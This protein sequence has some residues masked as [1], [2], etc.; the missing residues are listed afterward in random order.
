MTAQEHTTPRLVALAA[1][2]VLLLNYPI[3]YLF[4]RHGLVGGIPVLYLYLLVTWGLLILITALVLDARPF[5][6][7]ARKHPA[8]KETAARDA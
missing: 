1:L 4:G 8:P 7:S 5:T 2:G 6:R 3:L